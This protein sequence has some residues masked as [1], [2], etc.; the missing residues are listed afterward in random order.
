MK[1]K[2]MTEEEYGRAMR[3]LCRRERHRP[4][5]PRSDYLS[6]E[7]TTD[8]IKAMVLRYFSV[9]RDPIYRRE[10]TE[11]LDIEPDTLRRACRALVFAGYLMSQ[12]T[13]TGVIYTPTKDVPRTLPTR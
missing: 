10:L 4:G 13:Q 2:A 11:I 7:T 9:N 8:G 5:F 12:R 6:G 1:T 3:A